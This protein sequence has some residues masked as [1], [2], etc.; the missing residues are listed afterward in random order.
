M[1]KSIEVITM[2]STYTD[3]DGNKYWKNEEGQYNREDGPAIEWASGDKYWYQKGELHRLDGPAMEWGDGNKEWWVNGKRHRL[4]GPAV[5]Y[6]DGDRY[7]C[8][9]G[10]SYKKEQFDRIKIIDGEIYIPIYKI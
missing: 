8:I 6:A 5:E 2:S 1:I 9:N 10:N 7:Y 4:D 3:E